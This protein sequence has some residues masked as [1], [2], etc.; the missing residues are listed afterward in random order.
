MERDGKEY[1]AGDE[2]HPDAL[3]DGEESFSSS[4][5]F[6]NNVGEVALT[7]DS[8]ELNWDFVEP[9]VNVS[10]VRLLLNS[11]PVQF[12]IAGLLAIN[13]NQLWFEIFCITI[14]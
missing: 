9:L 1:I 7:L 6:L 14:I 12:V 3:L 11:N 8:H 10:A 5:L 2:S 4:N 13:P